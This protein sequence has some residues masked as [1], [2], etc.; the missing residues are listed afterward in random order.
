MTAAWAEFA[1]LLDE[2]LARFVSGDP[3]PYVRLWSDQD[4]IAIMGGFGGYE[5]G[6]AQVRAR[7]R[8]AAQQYRGGRLEVERVSTLLGSDLACIATIE[9]GTGIAGDPERRM[10]LRVTQVA[11]LG[12]AGWRIV[13]RHADVLLPTAAPTPGQPRISST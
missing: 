11:R 9:R 8:W 13:H 6:A 3:E 10:D 5:Q 1:T 12:P 2:A 4:D 7:L